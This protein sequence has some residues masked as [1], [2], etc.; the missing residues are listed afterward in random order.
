MAESASS[1]KATH[2]CMKTYFMRNRTGKVVTV[3]TPALYA[4]I[5]HQDLLSG[6]ACNRVGIRIVL[7]ADTDIAG[8]YPLD[9]NKQQHIE[10][11]ISFI[12]EPTELYFLKKE[13]MDWRR[14]HETNGYDLWHQGVMHCPNRNI[15]ETIPFTKGMEKLL[16]YRYDEHDKCPSCMIGKS[17]RQDV[18]GPAKRATR[19]LGKV[20]FDLIV[21]TVNSVEGYNASALFVDDHSGLKWLYG[22]QSKDEARDAAQIKS[23]M[24]LAR[25]GMAQSALGGK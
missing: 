3:T 13:D 5:I 18:P 2:A 4:K 24:T 17:T 6:K 23:T 21:S 19:P 12:P 1:M 14:F 15:R 10:E 8:L 25:S 9:A 7:D 11:S 20:N 16:S 22:L